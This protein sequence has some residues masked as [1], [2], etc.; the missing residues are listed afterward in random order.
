MTL[1][2]IIMALAAVGV[3]VYLVMKRKQPITEPKK[4]EPEPPERPII[5][6]PPIHPPH[7]EGMGMQ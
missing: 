2:F 4:Q 7:D 1:L 6:P 3:T 5:T